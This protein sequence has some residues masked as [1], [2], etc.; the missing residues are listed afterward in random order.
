[1][2]L[3]SWSEVITGLQRSVDGVGSA[4]PDVFLGRSTGSCGLRVATSWFLW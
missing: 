4:V 2:S 3:C 1:M